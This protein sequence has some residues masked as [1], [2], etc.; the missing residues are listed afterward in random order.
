MDR[1]WLGLLYQSQALSGRGYDS[2]DCFEEGKVTNE[3]YQHSRD[4]NRPF[5]ATPEEVSDTWYAMNKVA[6]DR[7]KAI[8]K[9]YNNASRSKCQIEFKRQ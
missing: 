5:T 3:E 7:R 1:S 6:I 2:R 4:L 9:K 8:C